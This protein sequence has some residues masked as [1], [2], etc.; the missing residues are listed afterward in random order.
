MDVTAIPLTEFVHGRINARTG[1]G[2]RINAQLAADLER[3]GLVRIAFA[4]QGRPSANRT[5]QGGTV[6]IYEPAADTAKKVPDDGQGQPSS[7]SPAAPASPTKMSPPLKR[8]AIR[9][10][11]TEK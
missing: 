11:K 3:A 2:I 4:P 5:E 1:Q 6:E 7:A 10:A 8:G 9:T